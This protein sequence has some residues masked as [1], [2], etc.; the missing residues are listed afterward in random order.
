M[1]FRRPRKTLKSFPPSTTSIP[2]PRS[3]IPASETCSRIRARARRFSSRSCASSQLTR[4]IV[5]FLS[6]SKASPT[7]TSPAYLQFIQALYAQMHARN[8]RLYVN[9]AVAT[10]DKDLKSIAANSDGIILM[11][12]D[13]HQDTSDPG[14][15]RQPAVVRRQS[16]PRAQDRAQGKNHLRHRQLRLRLDAIDSQ[17]QGSPPSQAEGSRYR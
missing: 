11:N 6:T 1:S 15:N 14:P 8:L 12:Y 16:R 9:V 2:T 13:E 5:A 4:S 7:P 10:S 17:S 3:G